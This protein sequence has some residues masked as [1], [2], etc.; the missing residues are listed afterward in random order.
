[1]TVE[2]LEEDERLQIALA[3]LTVPP[4]R[5]DFWASVRAGLE[6]AA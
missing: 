1:M 6:P 2:H 4:A 5:Q 3:S